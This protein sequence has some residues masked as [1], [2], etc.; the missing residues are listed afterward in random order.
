MFAENCE[1][2]SS[3]QFAEGQPL[4]AGA[5]SLRRG[6]AVVRFH[7][8]AEAVL[9]GEVELELESPGS[10]RL[11]HGDVV[12]R[13][14]DGAAGFTLHTPTSELTD[15]GTE[16]AVK[17]ARDG[18]TELQVLEGEVAYAP[19]VKAAGAVLDAGQA[20]RIGCTTAA[21]KPA[22]RASQAPCTVAAI[23]CTVATS[24]PVRPAHSPWI[25]VTT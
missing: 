1:W 21:S 4:P 15:L 22:D 7:G 8:G 13:A 18:A 17:V 10:A 5:L 16:F 23:A 24:E 9:T 25:G 2:A 11:R 12:I 6:T 19:N 20:V 14:E 3:A